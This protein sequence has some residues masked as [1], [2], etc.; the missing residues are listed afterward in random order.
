MERVVPHRRTALGGDLRIF[1]H[2]P[3]REYYEDGS[4]RSEG[5]YEVGARRMERTGSWTGWYANG[6]KE[7]T[8]H[9]AQNKRVG[10][11][12]LWH[13]DGDPKQDSFFED[14]VDQGPF[15]EFHPNGKLYASGQYRGI[16]G[17]KGLQHGEWKYY[18][19]DGEL[20]RTET[21]VNGRKK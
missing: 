21:W 3:F 5:Q 18:S 14:G 4:P 2:Q 19:E 11:W 10:R 8:G 1:P 13:P 17:G 12:L 16:R 7:Y 6:A 9:Y 15:K 20:V